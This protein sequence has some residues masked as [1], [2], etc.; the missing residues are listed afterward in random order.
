M[1]ANNCLVM[2]THVYIR[3]RRYNIWMNMYL[4]MRE[5]VFSCNYVPKCSQIPHELDYLINYLISF[6]FLLSV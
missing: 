3:V 5:H 1:A 4:R 6:F 2:V